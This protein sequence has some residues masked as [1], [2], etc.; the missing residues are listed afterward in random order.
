[1]DLRGIGIDAPRSIAESHPLR[2]PEEEA[3][4]IAEGET[5]KKAEKAAETL[6][7]RNAE[8][9][10]RKAFLDKVKGD[11][12]DYNDT[13]WPVT[14]RTRA[15]VLEFFDNPLNK[16]TID[17]KIKSAKASYLPYI[18]FKESDI[19]GVDYRVEYFFD[20]KRIFIKYE[21][22]FA[23][24]TFTLA[25]K[26]VEATTGYHFAE[27]FSFFYYDKYYELKKKDPKVKCPNSS[28]T[29]YDNEKI[30]IFLKQ[31]SKD[32]PEI[33]P[34]SYTVKYTKFI[35]GAEDLQGSIE[36]CLKYSVLFQD[37]VCPVFLESER[38]DVTKAVVKAV[39][40]YHRAGYC[41]NDLKGLNFIW[42]QVFQS[43]MLK[44]IVKVID[45]N[46][47]V[48]L[49]GS[50]KPYG[51]VHYLPIENAKFY[52]DPTLPDPNNNEE[53]DSWS[54]GLTILSDIWGIMTPW[55]T[56][57]WDQPAEEL[58]KEI[59]RR[60]EHENTDFSKLPKEMRPIVEGLL[61]KDQSKRMTAIQAD[62]LFSTMS[63]SI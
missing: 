14:I 12:E 11:P 5:R 55:N 50:T 41:H 53:K 36:K 23:A 52:Y 6:K 56:H 16:R 47:T 2:S 28:T 33:L 35:K 3:K 60:L 59:L 43:K 19:K 10:R 21:K 63:S 18:A 61:N 40:N 26:V 17:E 57:K 49:R 48:P 20:D 58:Q 39:A 22:R 27:T 44:M 30:E 46:D 8:E 45:Y 31:A 25:S 15:V 62:E 51:T 9:G 4:Q 1:M 34:P 42:R 24:G 38:I 29:W 13:G 54:L 7:L 32:I 37:H